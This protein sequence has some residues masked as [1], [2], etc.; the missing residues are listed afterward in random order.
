VELSPTAENWRMHVTRINDDVQILTI[1][2]NNDNRDFQNSR[3]FLGF[4]CFKL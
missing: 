1:P 3:F 4:D 2:G